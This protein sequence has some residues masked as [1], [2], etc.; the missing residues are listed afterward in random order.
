MGLSLR[1]GTVRGRAC[2]L[3]EDV[4]LLRGARGTG[5]Y[6]SGEE[7]RARIASQGAPAAGVVDVLYPLPSS[8]H[9]IISVASA[10]SAS[11]AAAGGAVGSMGLYAAIRDDIVMI[12]VAQGE[13]SKWPS[14]RGEGHR[15]PQDAGG[16]S[17]LGIKG[18]RAREM[19]RRRAAKAGGSLRSAGLRVRFARGLVLSCEAKARGDA[20]GSCHQEGLFVARDQSIDGLSMRCGSRRSCVQHLVGMIKILS[21]QSQ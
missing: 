11:R 4:S 9:H 13:E 3:Y 17:M 21:Q 1:R 14:F 8:H 15:S 10:V 16:V 20:A 2:A 12:I 7:E 6:A 18:Q 19:D 5:G